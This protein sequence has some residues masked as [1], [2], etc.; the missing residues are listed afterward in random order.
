MARSNLLK[1]KDS[2]QP[3]K[4]AT[5]APLMA[6]KPF[7]DSPAKPRKVMHQSAGTLISEAPVKVLFVFK[8]PETPALPTAPQ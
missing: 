7:G 4:S 3:V 8:N 5:D 6:S 2:A 1:K